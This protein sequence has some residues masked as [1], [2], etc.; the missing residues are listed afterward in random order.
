MV[1]EMEK[2]RLAQSNPLILLAFDVEEQE[3]GR[4]IVVRLEN[5]G[6]PASDVRFTFEPALVNSEDANIGKR[7]L[8]GENLPLVRPGE[9]RSVRFDPF[10]SYFGPKFYLGELSTSFMATIYS[11]DPYTKCAFD[12]T[13]I[14][15]DLEHLA[16]ASW[17]GQSYYPAQLAENSGW[18]KANPPSREEEEVYAR[19]VATLQEMGVNKDFL[20]EFQAPSVLGHELDRRGWYVSSF[21]GTAHCARVVAV[22]RRGTHQGVVVKARGWNYRVTLVFALHRAIE[23]DNTYGDSSVSTDAMY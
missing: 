9:V 22:K 5:Y 23:L 20:T 15:L 7:P 14:V 13:Q 10:G 6:G 16:P 1:S 12:P 3:G 4:N 21:D 18:S 2:Q 11:H 19:S 8:L 17:V